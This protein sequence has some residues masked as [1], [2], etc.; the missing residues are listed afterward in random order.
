MGNPR[1]SLV[2]LTFPDHAFELIVKLHTIMVHIQSS[3]SGEECLPKMEKLYT[4]KLSMICQGLA[5]TSFENKISHYLTS[6]AAHKVI[7]MEES[8]FTRTATCS[9][10]SDVLILIVLRVPILLIDFTY[11]LVDHFSSIV[12]L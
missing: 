8:R 6:G 2:W 3:I 1:Y 12:C 7:R 10:P 4:L 11:T 5:M 9:K